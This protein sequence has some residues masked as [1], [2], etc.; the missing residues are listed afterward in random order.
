M[1]FHLNIPGA[2][3]DP[4]EQELQGI[5][6]GYMEAPVGDEATEDKLVSVADKLNEPS[7]IDLINKKIA[8]LQVEVGF[9][10][11]KLDPIK[12]AIA[13][14][15]KDHEALMRAVEIAVL[16]LSQHKGSLQTEYN[17]AQEHIKNIDAEL[18]LLLKDKAKLL[19]AQAAKD[20]LIQL[21]KDLKEIWQNLPW[22]EAM[23]EYQN[24]DILFILNAWNEELS[25][26]L[27]ANDT[28][29]GKTFETG[30]ALDLLSELF[31]RKHD[32]RPR[33]LWLTAKSLV[34]QTYREHMKWNKGR[35]QV[36]VGMSA[37]VEGELYTSIKLG[38]DKKMRE[39]QVEMAIQNNAWIV[40]NYDALNTTPILTKIEWDIV[41]V[42]EVH[43]LKG[44]ANC[45][46]GQCK[47]RPEDKNCGATG[48]WKKT[49][50]I[51]NLA[52]TKPF[53][54][55]LSATPVQN[56]SRDIWAVWHLFDPDRF[57]TPARFEREF[58]YEEWNE[59]R[60]KKIIKCDVERLIKVLKH[61]VIRRTKK[62]V[63]LEL[64]DKIVE[65]DVDSR[66]ADEDEIYTMIRDNAF[67]ALD[68][69]GDKPLT[70]TAL[71]AMFHYLRLANISTADVH[72]KYTDLNGME[73]EMTLPETE[74]SKLSRTMEKIE[75]LLAEGEQVVVYS[76]Y[77]EPLKR[78][79]RMI[80]EAEFQFNGAGAVGK[81]KFFSGEENAKG[82]TDAI[83][84]GF[85]H[86]EFQVLCANVKA[87]G[88]GLNLQKSEQWKGGASNI[89]VLDVWWNPA[90]MT[91]AEDRVHRTGQTDTCF[92][93]YMTNEDSI[94]A[95]MAKI[96]AEKQAM[97]DGLMERDE[98][99][100]AFEWAEIL[101]GLI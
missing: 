12:Q 99:R 16:E 81:A 89:I 6:N 80:N 39:F 44:G 100:P 73:H 47:H 24:E 52:S 92:I 46:G 54:M 63:G 94:D 31:Y 87:G 74:S 43:K 13:Q 65:Y 86:G 7:E 101:K 68:S 76:T 25:G 61:Q 53:F 45:R 83:V 42:D 77:N 85:Q 48:L 21:T 4:V 70:I 29:L 78:L 28:G 79:T 40:T 10:Q 3:P 84:A 88:V 5:I 57:P 96:L 49:K 18:N 67:V 66:L 71:I 82:E 38:A 9:M 33:V 59:D 15:D 93:H 37:L 64:P 62:E 51:V 26:V 75:Q 30:A 32:R 50:E 8:D 27:N 41:I 17:V 19:E 14:V 90:V 60:T 56:K 58:C 35:I 22:Y 34:G 69:M 2:T 97:M 20:K 91:Q 1:E 36:V 23:K 55:P 11:S 98:I 95:F 72:Y